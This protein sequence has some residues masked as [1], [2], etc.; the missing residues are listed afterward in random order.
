M[1]GATSYHAGLV[2]EDQV[3]SLYQRRGQEICQR[4]WRG[5][6]GEIDL[7][8]RQDDRLIF[9]EVKRARDFARAAERLG[10]RQMRRLY[11]AAGE[12]LARMPM[13]L[14][15]EARFDVALVDGAGR[16]EILENAFGH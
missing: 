5:R 1:S 15:T 8:V 2:A 10:R 14:D 7:I 12:Y 6:G 9:V 3:A 11:D 16:I 13:G 4:R